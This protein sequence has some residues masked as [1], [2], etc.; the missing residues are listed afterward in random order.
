MIAHASNEN[1]FR[2][3]IKFVFSFFIDYMLIDFCC[4]CVT[5]LFACAVNHNQR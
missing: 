2:P 4:I 1:G 5:E 3:D